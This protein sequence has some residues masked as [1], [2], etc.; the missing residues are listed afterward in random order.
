MP[1]RVIPTKIIVKHPD[2]S[3]QDANLGSISDPAIADDLEQFRKE[4][5]RFIANGPIVKVISN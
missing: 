2:G 5:T 1:E 4:N 3:T